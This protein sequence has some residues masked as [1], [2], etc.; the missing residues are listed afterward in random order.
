MYYSI[1]M[2]H[3]HIL[4]WSNVGDIVLDPFAG[5]GTTGVEAIK[6][7]RKF[8]GIELAQEY[9][10]MCVKNCKALAPLQLFTGLHT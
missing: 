10:D 6:L 3:D 2:A 5:S 9:Y 1:A 4:S 8:I 7:E